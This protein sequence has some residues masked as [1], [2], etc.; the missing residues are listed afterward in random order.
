MIVSI[1][2]RQNK[3]KESFIKQL[4]GDHPSTGDELTY[5]T[6]RTP[7]PLYAPQAEDPLEIT[8]RAPLGWSCGVYI[9]LMSALHADVRDIYRCAA[10]YLRRRVISV[11][12]LP[13]LI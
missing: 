7:L 5:L 2:N 3:G 10:V 4:S 8:L 6:A 9:E 12:L 1:V 11:A 13:L